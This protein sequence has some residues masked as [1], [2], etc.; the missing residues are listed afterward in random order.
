MHPAIL[1]RDFDDT[2][3]EACDGEVGQIEL[4]VAMRGQHSPAV[5][6]YST[7]T[8]TNNEQGRMAPLSRR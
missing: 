4:C 6:A 8:A 2:A 3:R 5:C 1:Q 7:P